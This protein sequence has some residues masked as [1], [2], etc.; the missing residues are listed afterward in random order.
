MLMPPHRQ[1][2]VDID[3]FFSQF[4]EL[5]PAFGVAIDIEPSRGECLDGAVADLKAGAGQRR[6]RSLAQ[7]RLVE[8]CLETGASNGA[9]VMMLEERRIFEAEAIF[10]LAELCRLKP[11]AGSK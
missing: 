8:R 11:G 5:E 7:A 1:R 9:F 10:N 6:D 2:I 4:V 3:Q